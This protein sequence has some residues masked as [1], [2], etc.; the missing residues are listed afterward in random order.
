MIVH[1]QDFWETFEVLGQQL[2]YIPVFMKKL[3]DCHRAIMPMRVKR[4]YK[5]GC[6]KH[7]IIKKVSI[8]YQYTFLNH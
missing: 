5:D 1:P 6:E 8:S 7:G 4:L 3:S 2:S